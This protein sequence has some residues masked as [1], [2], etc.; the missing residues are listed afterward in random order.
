MSEVPAPPHTRGWTLTDPNTRY[1][2]SGSPAHAG[3]DPLR[4]VLCLTSTRLPRTR[5]DGPRLW[6]ASKGG[7]VAPPHTRGWTQSTPYM[8]YCQIGSPAHAGMDPI[9]GESA[10]VDPGLPRTRGDG[11]PPCGKLFRPRQ[12]PPH[13]RGWTPLS[14]GETLTLTGS[15]AH[16]GMDPITRR[17]WTQGRWLPRTRGD[18]PLDDLSEQIT[19]A[20]PPH[21]RGWTPRD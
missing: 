10:A 21:T 18:G 2:I 9:T 13:T 16:A 6:R 12:A 20:A 5:G 4:C 8:E 14:A 7:G 17:S 15:P 11:P 19:I 3:M 1:E